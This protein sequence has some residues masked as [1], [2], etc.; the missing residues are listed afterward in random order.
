MTSALTCRG[1]TAWVILCLELLLAPGCGGGAG[2]DGAVGPA[3]STPTTGDDGAVVA[4]AAAPGAPDIVLLV[5]PGLRADPVG[6]EDAETA[7]LEGLGRTPALRFRDAY[8]QSTATFISLGSAMTGRYP[9]AVPMCGFLP[10][11]YIAPGFRPGP[12]QDP[13]RGA[14]AASADGVDHTW[15]AGIPA[16]RHTLPELLGLYGYQTALFSD[17][18][19]PM[20]KLFDGRFPAS[21]PVEVETRTRSTRWP[22]LRD[23]MTRWMAGDAAEPRFSLV[24]LSDLSPE[25]VVRRMVVRGVPGLDGAA[26][27]P[28]DSASPHAPAWREDYL[29]QAREVGAEVGKLIGALEE[30]PG[31]PRW[32]FITSAHGISLGEMT[33]SGGGWPGMGRLR[34]VCTEL[35]VDRTVHVPL[36]VLGPGDG[37]PVE[38]A[39][40]VELVDLMPTLAVLG[41]APPPANLPGEDLLAA[42]RRAAADAVA[43]AEFGDQLG[44]RSGRHMIV[45]RCFEPGST[46]LD[47][48]MTDCLE[49]QIELV[50]KQQ[51][52]HH[53]FP[54]Q[55]AFYLHDLQADPREERDLTGSERALAGE[56]GQRMLD[57][58]LGAAAPPVGRLGPEEIEAL[59]SSPANTY[60]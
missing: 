10:G 16:D 11:A 2:G 25:S 39:G 28:D 23:H 42:D 3:G 34:N 15:C 54:D 49:E 37:E 51:P 22:G 53:H 24:V 9:S 13:G 19:P 5:I 18:G 29:A 41:G 45:L 48:E 33:G 44:L 27:A 20:R 30:V 6:L 4:D 1:R 35:L 40:P 31:R 36:L 56:L 57:L 43:Y 7:F 26:R 60:W 55:R 8:A 46:S 58:R 47:P 38:I 17:Q 59:R 21:Y 14:S 12:G 32:W 52:I 50:A